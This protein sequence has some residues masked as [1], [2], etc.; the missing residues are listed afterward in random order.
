MRRLHLAFAL[1]AAAAALACSNAG[2]SRL[3]SVSTTGIVKG[4]IFFDLDGN[5]VPSAGDDS[6]KNIH[7]K[8]VEKN[9]GDSVAAA[10]SLVTG[11]Y[12]MNSVPVGTYR[13]VVDTTPLAD[14][15][16]VVKIDSTEITV[17]PGDS[18]QVF[19]AV[20]YPHM[21]IARARS[22]AVPLGRKV[23]I[24]GITLNSLNTFGDTTV[25]VQDTSAAIRAARVRTP[26]VPASDS[27]RMRGTISTRAGQ[28]T[29]EDVT[30]FSIAST[31]PPPVQTV[32]SAQAASASVSA[33]AGALDARQLRVHYVTITDTL[34]VTGAFRLTVNDSVQTGALEV[35]LDA[36]AAPAFAAAPTCTVGC[37]YVPG[38]RFDIIGM[39]T[40]T[41]TPGVWRLKP[42]S[43]AETILL[44]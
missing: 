7:V 15:A 38:K 8:L 20:S 40:P 39:A 11:V 25:Y 16:R 35:L 29:I 31:L 4:L 36:S 6:V 10:I 43:A 13:I 3:L 9:S 12:R 23:F 44:P 24:Q 27:V 14:T 21:S 26:G 34:T 41:S 42:R 17:T 33:T 22:A 5:L 2:E 18:S 37:S 30:V 32:T 1:T 28:R 19:V